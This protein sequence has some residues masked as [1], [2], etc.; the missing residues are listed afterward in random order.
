MRMIKDMI[1]KRIAELKNEIH[2]IEM[3]EKTLPKEELICAKNGK[4]HKWY[5]KNAGKSIYLPKKER[6]LAE[7]LA[8]KKYYMLRKK[9][10][11]CELEACKAYIR[12]IPNENDTSGMLLKNAGY[13]EL[14]GKAFG[15]HSENLEAWMAEEYETNKK[16]PEKLN[17]KGTQGKYLRSKSEAMIDNVLFRERIPFRYENQ[18]VLDGIVMYPDFTIRHP[19]TGEYYYWEH[20]GM[21]DNSEYASH[22]CRKIKTYCDNGIIPSINLIMTYETSACPIG[23][24][25]IEQVAEYYF[26]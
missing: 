1:I 14:L 20:F 25:R 21:M 17:I 18:L 7:K 16:Y 12:K 11:M 2:E 26:G 5:L 6:H 9:D 8:M 13:V 4:G 3:L 23:M 19:K 15:P 24:E 22:A 10:L